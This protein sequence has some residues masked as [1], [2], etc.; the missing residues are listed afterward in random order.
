MFI[1]P[2]FNYK[3]FKLQYRLLSV[4]KHQG[5]TVGVNIGDYVQALASS[6]YYP[7]IDGFLDRDTDLAAY[8][9]EP[10][11]IIMN[12]WYMHNP[13]NWPPSGRIVPLFVALHIN[14]L[15]KEKMISRESIEYFKKHEPIG[16]RDYFTMDLLQK[17]GVDA[18]F[19]GCMTLTLGETYK[20]DVVE[21]KTYI[22]DP[23][24]NGRM[25][26]PNI[27][28]ACYIWLNHP[29][30]VFKLLMTKH[31]HVHSGN[32]WLYK[33]L[34]TALYY[35]EYTRVFGHDIVMNSE[36]VCQEHIYYARRFKNDNE[37]LKEAERLIK[38]YAKAKLVITSRIHC[39]LPCL[40]LGTSVIYLERGQDMNAS[41]CRLGGL[42][43]LFNSVYVNKGHLE[44]QFE[45]SLPITK[46]N[47]PVN[48]VTWQKLADKLT[49][50]CKDF[51]AFDEKPA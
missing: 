2:F 19:S 35:H 48:K 3:H 1:T 26:T 45:T 28:K 22:V 49:T 30:D 25:N 8:N 15:A 20:T 37:R 17:K 5:H 44:P 31:L 14:S 47:H 41:T 39:A 34:K 21:D 11:K 23:I 18:Y 46:K 13:S 29:V 36:Y 51:F 43:E 32:N 10:C 12:G 4:A 50:R 6:Q 33:V 7:K 24:Y 40:G 16:C 9:G 27:V 38:K 42:K